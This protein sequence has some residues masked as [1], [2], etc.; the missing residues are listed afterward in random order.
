MG[1]PGGCVPLSPIPQSV[2]H[3]L[4]LL[5]HNGVRSVMVNSTN[6]GAR[7]PGFRFWLYHG[8]AV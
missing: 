2:S 5:E 7:L 8:L 4:S 3:Q 1:P 6:A